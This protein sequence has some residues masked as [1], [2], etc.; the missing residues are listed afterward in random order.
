MQQRWDQF[1]GQVKPSIQ[2]LELYALTAGVLSWLHRFH[3]KRIIIFCDNQSMVGMINKMTSACRNCMV[4][5]HKI[6][7]HCLIYNG[8]LFAKFVSTKQNSIA[9]ISSRFQETRFKKL[10]RGK[11]MDKF[12]TEVPADI[13]PFEKIWLFNN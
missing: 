9:D 7:L 3:D 8:R 13:W 1:T 12:Q 2:Y 4:L 11:K 6:V 10:T 5:I